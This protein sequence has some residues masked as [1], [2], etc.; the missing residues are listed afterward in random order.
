MKQIFLASTFFQVV[1]LAAAIDAGTTDV[2]AYPAAVLAPESLPAAGVTE[3]ILLTSNHAQALELTTRLQDNRALAPALRRFDRVVDLN[4]TLHPQHPTSWRPAHED[5]PLLEE[6]LRTR[7]GLGDGTVELVVES[8]Q[9][10]PAIALGRV[11]RSAFIRV[12]SDGLMSYGPTRSTIP[13]ANGQRMTALHHLPLVEGLTPR[14][15]VEYGIAPRPTPLRAFTAVVDEIAA[16]QADL[17]APLLDDLDGATTGLAFGQ[18]LAALGL[19]TEDEESALHRRMVLTAAERG[20]AAL[21]FKPHPAAPPSRLDDIASAAREA[22]IRLRVLDTPVFAEAIVARLRPAVVIGSFSTA[23]ATARAAYG[24]PIAVLGTGPLLETIAPYQNSNRVPVTIM[25]ELAA[26]GPAAPLTAQ[27][28]GDLQVLVDT[29]SYCMQP[30][31]LA[32]FRDRASAFL[33]S[34]AGPAHRLHFKRRRLTRLGLPGALPKSRS[35]RTVAARAARTAAT[36]TRIYGE[37]WTGRKL[38]P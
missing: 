29:V 18:Y 13:L 26:V 36:F 28:S 21:A 19:M 8:P 34:P 16:D 15:L 2:P 9:V 27:Q 23:L 3:R 1:S 35:P 10:N 20:L 32:A 14:L 12:H 6:A 38:L 33:D 25:H 37:R 24:I 31:R 30:S 11:F 7:W 4:D 17:L 22:G 5:L